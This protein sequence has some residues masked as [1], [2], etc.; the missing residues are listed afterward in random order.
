[1]YGPDQLEPSNVSYE[2]TLFTGIAPSTLLVFFVSSTAVS[3]SYTENPFNL[4]H[5]NVEEM[6]VTVES[7][8]YPG[9]RL[10]PIKWSDSTSVAN[11]RREY[12][13]FIRISK[14]VFGASGTVLSYNEFV[15]TPFYVILISIVLMA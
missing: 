8:E 3:G 10:R 2:K 12:I 14:E 5:A 1:M 9:K 6:Y 7:T 4:Q 11:V 13:D 15:R